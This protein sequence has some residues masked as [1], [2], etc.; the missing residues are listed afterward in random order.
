V[1]LLF[2][3]G[4]DVM[5]RDG[6][7]ET[8]LM[9]AVCKEDWESASMLFAVGGLEL[10]AA[11]NCLEL[12]CLDMMPSGCKDD[13]GAAT[14]IKIVQARD[15]QCDA[16][17][18]S[19]FHEAGSTA[20]ECLELYRGNTWDVSLK[21]ESNVCA[22][23]F[24]EFAT[25][26]AGHCMCPSGSAAYYELQVVCMGEGPQ[27]GFCSEAFEQ[28][29]GHSGNGV[30]D[31]LSSWGVDGHRLLKWHIDNTAFGGRKWQ[32]G[33]VI[34]L[35]CDL[36]TQRG[37]SKEM[38]MNA[39]DTCDQIQQESAG[40]ESIWVSLNGDF[41]PPYGVA[42]HLPQG[43]SGL[44]AAFSFQRGAV[45]CNLG[46]EPF[47]YAPPGEGFMPMCFFSKLC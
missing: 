27:W 13:Q 2:H 25:V 7:G 24:R 36:R 4:S 16:F 22:V 15:E 23:L 17:V 18:R 29:H 47:E 31:N 38:Q 1:Q 5:V 8:L 6:M 28:E 20:A 35:A 9:L 42:F 39:S 41:S 10:L 46:E 21:A 43:L 32:D 40:G 44:F 45:R 37:V 3:S 19:S 12:T 11:Q 34:G 30:G 14:W 33:D 26:R